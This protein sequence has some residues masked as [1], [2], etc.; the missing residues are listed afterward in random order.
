MLPRVF[1]HPQ[2][3]NHRVDSKNALP[4]HGV[5][6]FRHVFFAEILSAADYK[7]SYSSLPL[8][9]SSSF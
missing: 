9:Y 3:L 8:Q 6:Q 4:V 5:N 2:D 1:Q 7:H